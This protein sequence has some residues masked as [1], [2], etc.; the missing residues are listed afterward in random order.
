MLLTKN[1]DVVIHLAAITDATSS[2]EQSEEVKLVNYQGTKRIAEACIATD[3]NL[4][5]PS[6]TSVYGSQSKCVDETCPIEELK[7]QSPYAEVKLLEE[8]ILR[9]TKRNFDYVSLRFGTIVGPSTGMRFHTA[10]NKFCMQAYL[11]RPLQVWKTALHQYRPYLSIRDAFKTFKFFIKKKN[12]D[13]DIYNIVSENITVNDI[14]KKIEKHKKTKIKLVN[15]K[16]MN[17]LSYKVSS[18]KVKKIGLNL[19]SKIQEDI[20]STFRILKKKII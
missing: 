20:T 1:M 2:F 16:I 3:T 4:L 14:I 12:F 19:S 8:R 10:V 7:P 15:E 17:Q 6:T 9:K 13:R 5:F 11:N 18:E